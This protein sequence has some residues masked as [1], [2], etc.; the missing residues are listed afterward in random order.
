[1]APTIFSRMDGEAWMSDQIA[2]DFTN[3][4]NADGTSGCSAARIPVRLHL[5]IVESS[6]WRTCIPTAQAIRWQCEP[7]ESENSQDSILK[8]SNAILLNH[9]TWSVESLRLAL[10][11]RNMSNEFGGGLSWTYIARQSKRASSVGVEWRAI[12]ER[13]NRKSKLGNT[14]T[15]PHIRHRICKTR[16]YDTF[17][18]VRS[19]WNIPCVPSS[20]VCRRIWYAVYVWWLRSCCF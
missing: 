16:K 19:Y 5:L 15:S 9:S 10:T 3:A 11:E 18:M 14:L 17:W 2:E 12:Q 13:F 6:N 7:V 4:E 20:L 8:H 1:M